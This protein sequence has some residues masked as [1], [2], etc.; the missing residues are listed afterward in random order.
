[1][2]VTYNHAAYSRIAIESIANQTYPHIEIVVVDDGSTDGNDKILKEV[3]EAS[4]RP[5]KLLLQ[6]NTGNV[7]MNCNRALA[8]AT[9]DYLS[10]LSLDDILYP[11][12][13]SS[14]MEFLCADSNLAFVANT[15][16]VEIDRDGHTTNSQFRSGLFEKNLSSAEELLEHEFHNIGTFYVQGAVFRLDVI[17]KFGGYDEDMVGDDLI[18]RTKLFQYMITHPDLSFLL[19]HR[20][21]MAYR[22]HDT[23][24]HLNVWRQV[25][26]VIEWKNRYFPDRLLPQL[27]VRWTEHLFNQS[28]KQARLEDIQRAI[29]F[30]PQL[31]QI[32]QAYKST[33]KGRRRIAKATIR[34]VFRYFHKRLLSL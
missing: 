8:A 29:E 31:N 12:C 16:N 13:I 26:T 34:S 6:E 28:A 5:F 18:F 9:G 21:G 7:A 4:G 23:N 30:D 22:K 3:L 10:V 24:I 2:C 11:D 19:M 1:M 20:P 25:K 15:C 14:K 32:Y 33:W 27:A 17:R